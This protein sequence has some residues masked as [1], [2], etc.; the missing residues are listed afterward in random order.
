MLGHLRQ[1]A[2]AY[3]ALFVALSGTGYAAIKLPP[4][5]VG[6]KQLRRNA[7][8]SNRIKNGQVKGGDV[9][10]ASLGP[11][12]S[13]RS[14]ANANT[15]DHLGSSAFLRSGATAGGALAGSYPSPVIAAGAVAT[16]ELADGSVSNAKLADGSVTNAKLARS[17]R[18]FAVIGST[19]NV[20]L[21]S[22][23]DITAS[24]PALGTYVVSFGA[25]GP[26]PESC[27]VV[28]TPEDSAAFAWTSVGAS[29]QVHMLDTTGAPVDHSF[30]LALECV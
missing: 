21:K 18:A 13:A 4:N 30:D 17:A 3:L 14:A 6:T 12:P 15:L 27:A 9:D 11:V 19:G 29:V 1:N 20:V 8:T 7:V 28:V 22:E 24:H 23:P 2:V 25:V 5:S 10:E 16:Q 26:S